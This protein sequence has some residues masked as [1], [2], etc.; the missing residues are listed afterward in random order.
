MS[1]S[2]ILPISKVKCN[3]SLVVRHV[4][5]LKNQPTI[6]NWT[7]DKK[8]PKVYQKLVIL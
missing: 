5:K 4:F 7:L 8:M 1:Q 2:A 6:Q 3:I